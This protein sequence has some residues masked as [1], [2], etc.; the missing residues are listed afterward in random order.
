MRTLK[1][2]G[3]QGPGTRHLGMGPRTEWR[4]HTLCAPRDFVFP[5][6]EYL[7]Y[8]AMNI[9]IKRLEW[10]SEVERVAIKS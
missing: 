4:Q 7:T 2:E 5:A 6:L 9:Y 10:N 3:K 8:R 1:P